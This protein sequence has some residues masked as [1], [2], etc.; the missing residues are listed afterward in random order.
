[1]IWAV[2]GALV[3]LHVGLMVYSIRSTGRS[4][5]RKGR[6]AEKL[7]AAAR[8]EEA[9]DAQQKAENLARGRMLLRARKWA[10]ERM[11]NAGRGV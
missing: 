1:M 2:F 7:A 4:G 11:Q 8:G 10:R 5:E 3:A 6:D 9:Q